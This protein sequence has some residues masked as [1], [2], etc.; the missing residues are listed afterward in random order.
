MSG[1][2]AIFAPV[3]LHYA[4]PYDR[5]YEDGYLQGT[6]L[7][8]RFMTFSSWQSARFSKT[9]LK[10]FLNRE[11]IVQSSFRS[12][13]IVGMSHGTPVEKCQ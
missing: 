12:L 6:S 10:V 5:G 1:S 7:P 3:L 11:Y 13:P 2:H 8:E 4:W 9:R